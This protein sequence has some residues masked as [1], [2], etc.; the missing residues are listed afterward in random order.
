M[1]WA[2]IITVVN[3]VTERTIGGI[4]VELVNLDALNDRGFTVS[5]IVSGSVIEATISGSR[6]EVARITSAEFRAFA[7]MAGYRKGI[8]NVPINLSGPGNMEIIQIRPETI[9]VEVVDLITVF[10]Q[11]RLELDEELPE[12]K[13]LGFI[14]IIPEEMEVTGVADAVDSVDYVRAL[15]KEGDL[16]EE[17]STL[18]VDITAI[19]KEGRVV[20]NVG[21]SQSS[22]EVTGMICTVK[23]VP[24]TVELIGE[25]HES[26]E[27]TDMYIP[28]YVSIR[29]KAADIEGIT[30]AQTRQVDLSAITSTTEILLEDILGPG[31]PEGVEIADASKNASVRIEVQGIARKEFRFTADMIEVVNL[32]PSLSGHVNTG[33]VIVTVL[34]TRDVLAMVTQERI[35]LTV[36]ASDSRWA[37]SLIELDVKAEIDGIEVK[38]IVI[39]PRKVRVTIVRE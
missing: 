11:V 26:I 17:L 7:D 38:D 13:E 25:P 32:L 19:N 39:E 37:A 20:Y 29:G 21:F 36:D 34:A 10:K 4:P 16:T 23:Q 33:S 2:Y 6:S 14:Q 30:A 1:L 35:H 24:L 15:A 31:L 8:A 3:P 27:V 5:G 22:V 28:K 9:E 12:G 18:R